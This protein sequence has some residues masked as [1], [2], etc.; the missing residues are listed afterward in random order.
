MK[1]PTTVPYKTSARCIICNEEDIIEIPVTEK[2]ENN[3][4]ETIVNTKM[5]YVCGRSHNYEMDKAI[6]ARPQTSKKE[7]KIGGMR[8]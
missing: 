8:I 5:K 3:L 2:N 4:I 1:D 6:Y 7:E